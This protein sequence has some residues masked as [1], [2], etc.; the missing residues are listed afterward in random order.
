MLQVSFCWKCGKK[1]ARSTT[2]KSSGQVVAEVR[3]YY[4]VQVIMHKYC[5][6]VF[7]KEQANGNFDWLDGADAAYKY[8]E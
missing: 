6:K 2:G 8:T 5:A 3:D 7:D 1:L 4:G